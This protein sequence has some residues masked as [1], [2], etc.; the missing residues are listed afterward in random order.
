MPTTATR[1]SIR[2]ADAEIN[3][4]PMIDVLLVLLVIFMLSQASFN[5]LPAQL[6]PEHAEA[7]APTQ[8]LQ[9]V[10]EV[11]AHGR[12]A[13][14]AQPVPA[15][16]LTTLLRSALAG[17]TAK[18]VFLRAAADCTYQEVVTAMDIAKGAGAQA[19]AFMPRSG[20]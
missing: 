16:E 15:A 7:A 19:V 18:L 10:L 14:N 6:P 1:P 20:D 3:V 11:A 13:V 12:Y 2:A 9:I 8:E 17:R 4:T 5:L